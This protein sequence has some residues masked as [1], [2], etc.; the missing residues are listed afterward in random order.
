MAIDQRVLGSFLP[1]LFGPS[2]RKDQAG[3]DLY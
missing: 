2:D 1:S 3:V